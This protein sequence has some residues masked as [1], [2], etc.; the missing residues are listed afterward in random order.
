MR[1]LQA[2]VFLFI[3]DKETVTLPNILCIILTLRLAATIHYLLFKYLQF[4]SLI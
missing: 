3:Y 4:N 1:L 2:Q